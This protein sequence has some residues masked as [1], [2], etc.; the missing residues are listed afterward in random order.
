MI[1][2]VDDWLKLWAREVRGGLPGRT[3]FD[4]GNVIEF[5]GESS[6]GSMGHDAW[7]MECVVRK[8]SAELR[9][10]IKIHYLPQHSITRER[11]QAAAR[12]LG[13]RPA[14]IAGL[15]PGSIAYRTEADKI[16]ARQQSRYYRLLAMTHEVIAEQLRAHL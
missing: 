4:L 16:F 5:E 15:L 3:T 1:P 11:V 12:F 2:W 14:P 9:G 10:I 8:L 6:S 13:D 7:Q